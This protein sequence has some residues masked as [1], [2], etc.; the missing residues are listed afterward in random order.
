LQN[1]AGIQTLMDRHRAVVAPKFQAV[2]D[3]FS[4]MLSGTPGVSWTSPKGGYFIAL[5][6]PRGCAR[7]VVQLAKDA[8]LELTPAG[9]THPYGKDP[10]DRVIRVAPTFPEL[11]EVRQA[12]EGVAWSVLMACHAS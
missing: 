8:G 3:V 9:A 10:D 5:S 6:V 4:S 7:R 2:L 11:A 1:E 12:A